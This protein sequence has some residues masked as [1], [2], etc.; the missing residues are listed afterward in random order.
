MYNMFY[1]FFQTLTADEKRNLLI[2]LYNNCTKPIEII[3]SRWSGDLFYSFKK[4]WYNYIVRDKEK[5]NVYNRKLAS[6]T[7]K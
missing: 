1:E 6:S 2:E 7:A 4:F 5:T 3:Q